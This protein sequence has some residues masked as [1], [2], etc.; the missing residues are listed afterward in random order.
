[1]PCVI[2]ERGIQTSTTEQQGERQYDGRRLGGSRVFAAADQGPDQQPERQ[3]RE[4][5]RDEK[6]YRAHRRSSV[7]ITL[8]SPATMRERCRTMFTATITPTMSSANGSSH[9]H[10]VFALNG[11]RNRMKLP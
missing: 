6:E 3:G 5:A 7:S 4:R 8:S 2:A 11:G 10:A 9:T 1:M